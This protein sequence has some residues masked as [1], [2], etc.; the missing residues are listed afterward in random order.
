MNKDDFKCKYFNREFGNK[1]LGVGNCFEKELAKYWPVEI[2]GR[3]FS[4][5]DWKVESAWLSFG[6]NLF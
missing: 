3:N 4:E 5:K 6:R 2:K 1:K